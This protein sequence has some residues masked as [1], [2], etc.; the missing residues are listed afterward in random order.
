MHLTVT[1]MSQKVFHSVTPSRGCCSVTGV[2][3]SVTGGVPRRRDPP[4]IP[5]DYDT[6]YVHLMRVLYYPVTV[7]ATH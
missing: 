4:E 7:L 1:Q 3:H 2:F 6:T 5:S